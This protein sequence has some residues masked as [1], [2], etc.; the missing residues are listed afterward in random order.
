[1]PEARRR[2]TLAYESSRE[3]MINILPR[4]HDCLEEVSVYS[5]INQVTR[6]ITLSQSRAIVGFV[7]AHPVL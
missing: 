4:P 7:F 2:K 3:F 5:R 6:I 1:M